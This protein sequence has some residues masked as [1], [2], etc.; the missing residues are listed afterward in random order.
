MVT[1]YQ[2]D[3]S[4]SAAFGSYFEGNVR[5]PGN[6]MVQPRTHFW[7]RLVVEGRLDL[8]PQS[9]VGEDVE[10]D[11]AAIGSNSWIKG[12]L[13]SVGDILICD[14]AHLHDIVSGG[15]VT[16]RSGARV[17]NVTARD[18]IIIYGK[19]KSGKLVGKNV[20]IYGKDGSQ[21]VLPSDAKPE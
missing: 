15:N 9:V 2:K 14:N 7:G 1:V 20:K 16:L 11:S 12:T 6:F 8:G 19:I 5:I 10:C 21:P 3:N 13:R 17:G 18:T 4:Y